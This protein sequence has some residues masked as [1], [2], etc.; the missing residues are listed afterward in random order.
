MKIGEFVEM[1]NVTP[2]MLRHYNDI[3]LLKPACIDEVT[4]YRS[5]DADQS[6]Y[7]KERSQVLWR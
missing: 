4:D 7:L 3:D 2:K 1:N 6:N 5:Y